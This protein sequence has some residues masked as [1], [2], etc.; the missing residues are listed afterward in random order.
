MTTN[1]I[2]TAL[3]LGLLSALLVIGGGA[4]GGQNGLYIGLG[5][6]ALMNFGSYF[7][8]DKIAL[9]MYGA[10]PMKRAIQRLVQDPLALKLINAEFMEGDTVLV[11]A[12]PEGGELQFTKLVPVEA[13]RG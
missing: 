13:V 9:S 12:A 8:S 4:L 6:A 1:T 10:R 3:L 2:K 5:I 11:D 7:F